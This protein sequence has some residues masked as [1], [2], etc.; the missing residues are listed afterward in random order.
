MPPS[1]TG[2]FVKAA[3]ICEVV[4]EGK[5]GVLTLVRIV[6]RVTVNAAGPDPPV[7]MPEVQRPLTF[8]IMLTSG[9]ARGTEEVRLEE[10]SPDA[11]R[12]PVWSGSVLFEGEDRGQNLI[13]NTVATFSQQGL[14]WFDLFVGSQLMSRMPFRLIYLRSTAGSTGT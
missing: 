12:T 7:E 9:M 13:I 10:E 5:D 8:A 6:D 2:P 4:V 3:A 1:N 14:Y 11:S